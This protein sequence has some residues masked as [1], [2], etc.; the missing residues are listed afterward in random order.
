MLGFRETFWSQPLRE[1]VTLY[2]VM[3]IAVR[4]RIVVCSVE[5]VC[6]VP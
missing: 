5:V 6:K 4:P 1:G 3:G 2:A